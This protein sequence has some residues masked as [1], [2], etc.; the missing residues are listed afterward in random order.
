VRFGAWP[1][2]GRILVGL[3]DGRCGLGKLEQAEPSDL[4]VSRSSAPFPRLI[5][6]TSL[7]LVG[8]DAGPVPRVGDRCGPAGALTVGLSLEQVG[9]RTGCL[10]GVDAAGGETIEELY[11]RLFLEGA[12]RANV[13]SVPRVMP[14]APTSQNS[15]AFGIRGPVF[16]VSS[17]VRRP[18]TRSQRPCGARSDARARSFQGRQ[19]PA[20]HH[21]RTG[22][23]LG[24][25]SA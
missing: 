6:A 9:H 2:G 17:H 3:Q 11:R 14:S 4:R 22:L 8:C 18:T 5:L 21:D 15:M 16:T 24:E 25:A 23:A 7:T 1:F 20:T 19:P 10:V 12:K 13:F